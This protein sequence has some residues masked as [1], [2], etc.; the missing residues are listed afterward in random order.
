MNNIIRLS[1]VLFSISLELEG[2]LSINVL[3]DQE[4]ADLKNSTAY[5]VYNTGLAEQTALYYKAATLAWKIGKIEVLKPDKYKDT[6]I[7]GTYSVFEEV[8]IIYESSN[9]GRDHK[10]FFIYSLVKNDGKKNLEK[11]EIAKMEMELSGSGTNT[12]GIYKCYLSL[13]SSSLLQKVRRHTIQDDSNDD[14]LKK[15]ANDTLFITKDLLY[16][17]GFSS[18]KDFT[19][20]YLVKDYKYKYQFTKNKKLTNRILS[21]DKEVFVFVYSYLDCKQSV[22]VVEAHSGSLVYS[23]YT[24]NNC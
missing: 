12:P 1:F 23:N 17:N 9:R 3:S 22:F 7:Q 8:D 11:I 4:L 2:Q 24:G 21:G 14:L 16:G 5:F 13:I 19:E 6:I 10:R 15:L 20:E 18:G